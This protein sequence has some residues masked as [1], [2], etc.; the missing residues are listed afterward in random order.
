MKVYFIDS[1]KIANMLIII[2]T[3]INCSTQITRGKFH[4]LLST[5]KLLVMAVL[6]ENR[7]GQLTP[8]MEEFRGMVRAVLERNIDRYR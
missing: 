8:D 4:H 5:R 6:E 1:Y 2:S 3:P 7:I